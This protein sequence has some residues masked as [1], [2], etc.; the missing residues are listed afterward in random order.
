VEQAGDVGLPPANG[1]DDAPPAPADPGTTTVEG[2][3]QPQPAAA[4]GAMRLDAQVATVAERRGLT[5]WPL[6]FATLALLGSSTGLVVVAVHRWLLGRRSY[7]S[8]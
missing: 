2:G 3:V 6:F 1:D 5:S 8:G 4:T 7:R